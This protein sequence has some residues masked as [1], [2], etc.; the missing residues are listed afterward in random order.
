[1]HR[2]LQSIDYTTKDD[3][4]QKSTCDEIAKGLEIVFK[5][6]RLSG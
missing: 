3:H 1:M 2:L 4:L 6:L 5:P